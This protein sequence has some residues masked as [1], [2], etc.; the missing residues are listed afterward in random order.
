MVPG[1]KIRKK[2]K[3]TIMILSSDNASYKHNLE[4]IFVAIR[5]KHAKD[6]Y[7]IYQIYS[8]II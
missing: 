1:L 2:M 8:S 7:Q 6:L 3:K 5:L 4:P